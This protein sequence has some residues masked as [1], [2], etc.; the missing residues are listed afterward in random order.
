MP[1]FRRIADELRAEM[2][3]GV[4]AAGDQIPTQDALS[5]RFKVSRATV[6]RA[7][8]ELR[9]GDYIDSQ[10]GRGSY[11]LRGRTSSRPDHE[12]RS[13]SGPGPAG[14]EL[15]EHLEAA[16]RE[17]RVTLDSFS[18]TAETLNSALQGPLRSIQAGEIDPPQSVAVRLLLPEP[19]A[20]LAVPRLV[21]DAGDGRPMERLRR[22]AQSHAHGLQGSVG[23]LKDLGLVTE[24]SVEIRSVKVTP[25]NKLYLINGTEALFGYY[26]VVERTV[27]YRGEDMEIY[28]FLGLGA[29]LFHY[30][31]AGAGP[32]PYSAEYVRRSQDWFDSIWS[33]IAEPL[34]LF[35]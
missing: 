8:D 34:R 4:L 29:T 28:D 14:V 31:A 9:K 32:D 3:S 12:G 33:T 16:F 20:Q 7:L 13:H 11:V 10:R 19:G 15:A 23:R 2:D 21:G 25:V 17:P 22:L 30:S 6:Q 26:K 27:S 35:E 24:A 1:P 5:R 18:L